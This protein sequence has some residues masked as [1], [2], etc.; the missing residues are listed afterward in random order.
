LCIQAEGDCVDISPVRIR[1]AALALLLLAPACGSR[2][3]EPAAEAA[4][5]AQPAGSAALETMV[6]PQEEIGGLPLGLRVSSESGWRDNAAE[7]ADSL[8]PD[9]SEASIREAGRLTGY[10]LTYADPT[11]AALRSGSGIDTV[12][13]W[14]DL[15]SSEEAASAYLSHRIDQARSLAGTSPREGI[16]VEEVEPFE[17]EVGEEAYGLRDVVLFGEDRVFRTRFSFRRGRIVGGGMVIRA[18]DAD[19]APDAERV[20]GLLDSR[21]QTGLRGGRNGEPVLVSKDGVPLDGQQPTTERPEGAPDLA[22]VALGADEIPVEFLCDQG[23][24]R[25]TEPPRVTFRRVFC[26]NGAAIG[27]TR[28]IGLS[29]Q[30]SSFESDVAAEA[31]LTLSGR[32]LASADGAKAYAANFAATSGLVATGVKRRKVAIPGGDVGVVTTFDT[33]AGRLAGFSALVQRGTGVGTLDAIGLAKGFDHRDLL[34]LVEAVERR[35]Q[36]L[37]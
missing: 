11:Q 1:L 7:A 34:P 4:A 3:S 36:R 37:E 15:F 18:D 22:A 8:D 29:T 5:E 26:P 12:T 6:V 30:V 2:A 17:L 31:S 23:Q 25:R 21:I 14:V 13:T 24:Y 32:M 10:Q 28:L 9:D 16:T 35:L 33:D 27:G 20:A 19:A